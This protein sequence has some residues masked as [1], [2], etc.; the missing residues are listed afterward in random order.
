MTARVY[1]EDER[2]LQ[3]VYSGPLGPYVDQYASHMTRD[4]YSRQSG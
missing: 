4:G 3:K 1:F 2:S